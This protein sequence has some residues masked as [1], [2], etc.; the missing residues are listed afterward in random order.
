MLV[1]HHMGV[2]VGTSKFFDLGI[3]YQPPS[4]IITAYQCINP[5]NQIS[6]ETHRELMDSPGPPTEVRPLTRMDA[7]ALYEAIMS[8]ELPR[9]PCPPL[10]LSGLQRC[11]VM[12]GGAVLNHGGN[13]TFSKSGMSMTW[14]W[15][16]TVTWGSTML[17]NHF[18]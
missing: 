17:G 12:I 18:F 2:T 9:L 13:C 11:A 16:T 15:K 10:P 4:W 3:L 8:G 14:Y 6:L 7:D 1:S 5:Q